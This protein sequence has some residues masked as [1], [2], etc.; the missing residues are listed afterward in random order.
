MGPWSLTGRENAERLLIRPEWQAAFPPDQDDFPVR[1]AA[2]MPFLHPDKGQQ[3][4]ESPLF[5]SP[6]FH[7]LKAVRLTGLREMRDHE[8][9]TAESHHGRGGFI[10]VIR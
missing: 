8:P 3:A 9:E 4:P 6:C 10:G 1:Q 7:A 5:A 2:G